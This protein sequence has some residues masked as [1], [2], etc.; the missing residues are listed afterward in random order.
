MKASLSRELDSHLL[1]PAIIANQIHRA[2]PFI[3]E[4]KSVSIIEEKFSDSF[5]KISNR[6]KIKEEKPTKV[7]KKDWI[8]EKRENV[9][10]QN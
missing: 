9:F 4:K 7:V 3:I 6:S 10:R 1:Q 2:Y 8:I 5:S